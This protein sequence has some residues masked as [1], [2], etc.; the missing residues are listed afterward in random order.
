MSMEPLLVICVPCRTLITEADLPFLR[1]ALADVLAAKVDDAV[2]AVLLKGTSE[3]EEP[4]GI[5][6]D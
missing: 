2:G 1:A 6:S 4:K 5:L 3:D